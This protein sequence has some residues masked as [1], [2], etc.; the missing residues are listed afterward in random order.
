V[1]RSANAFFNYKGRDV[2]RALQ[3][4]GALQDAP[5]HLLVKA[6][7]TMFVGQGFVYVGTSMTS[8]EFTCAQV[9]AALVVCAESV[10]L[11]FPGV[12]ASM[13]QFIVELRRGDDD[14]QSFFY[15]PNRDTARPSLGNL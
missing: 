2:K 5:E 8:G 15:G 12:C 9:C 3:R 4:Y 10:G 11:S 14:P 1:L 13:R 7:M 6:A